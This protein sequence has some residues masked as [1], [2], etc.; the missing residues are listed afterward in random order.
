M[1][2]LTGRVDT[3]FRTRTRGQ[4]GII[5]DLIMTEDAHHDITLCDNDYLNLVHHPHILAAQIEDLKSSAGRGAV[6]SPLFLSRETMNPHTQLEDDLG[7][8]YG[9]DCYLAQ[10]GYAANV[11]LMHALCLP[12]TN[13]YADM[14]VHM[15]FYDGLAA[16]KVRLHRCQLNDAADMEDKI[17]QHGPGLILV[18]SLYSVSGDFAPLVDMVRLR[19]EYGCLLVVDESHSL[20]VYGAKGLVHLHGL[21][22]EVDYVTASLA[23]AFS[24][25]AGVVFGRH[26]LF[27]KEHS[28]PN[29]FSS[30]LLR[31][32]IVRIRAAW[33]VI[34]DADDRR[35]R[36]L[37]VSR[38]LRSELGEVS[39]LAS[40]SGTLPSP[41][42]SL[43]ADDEEQ[44][45]R[46]HRHLSKKGILGAPFFPPATSPKH[47]VLRLTV[48]ANIRQ[49]D[50]RRIVEG[51][52]S[53]YAITAR[54][55]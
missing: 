29:I 51:V 55:V 31:N 11:G 35:A 26:G 1:E 46:L 2:N 34:C 52:A 53:F 50:V 12:G 3:Y 47:P 43:C 39:R 17:R 21:Q 32:D 20:G 27:V 24:T 37:D 25:R 23:K 30:A 54:L 6:Y 16:R 40:V 28:F 18:E 41:I 22:D 8:W 38:R 5:R 15:S 4:K 42:V 49:E 14:F 13:V 19:N 33:E 36:L 7:A 48:H 44:M 45:A 9:K 10:S